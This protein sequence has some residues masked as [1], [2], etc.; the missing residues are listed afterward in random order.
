MQK[1]CVWCNRRLFEKRIIHE[2]KEFYLIA[3]LGQ[4]TDGGHVLVVPKRHILCMGEVRDEVPMNRFVMQ[5]RRAVTWG[6]RKSNARDPLALS[7]IMFED[8]RQSRS[9]THACLHIMPTRLKIEEAILDRYPR[10]A[11]EELRPRETIQQAYQERPEPYLYW[12]SHYGYRTVYWDP[13]ASMPSLR[14]VVA[15]LHG[16]PERG[17][18]R[19]TE[20]AHDEMLWRQTMARLKAYFI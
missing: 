20:P 17:D 8:A 13:P 11:L 6:Y 2:T 3:A 1:K 15:T 19:M 18:W 12:T 5:V 7:T 10:L 16:V 14:R 4:I 9:G